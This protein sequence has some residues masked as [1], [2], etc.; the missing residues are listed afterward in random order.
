MATL[1]GAAVAVFLAWIMI[2]GYVVFRRKTVASENRDRF[3]LKLIVIASPIIWWIAIGLAF[4]RYGSMH[5]AAL[6][7]G[8]L[9]LMAIGIAIRSTAIAQLGRLHTPNVAVREDHRLKATGLY[10]YVRHPSYLGALL[11]FLGMSFALG[12]WL[13][14]ALIASTTPCIYLYRIHEEDTALAAAFGQAFQVYRG[15]TKRLIPWIY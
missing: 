9:A 8:G 1:R 15:R 14:V 11:A 3:S 5:L 4:G 13:S 2:D 12:N 7:V 10:R 6:Q